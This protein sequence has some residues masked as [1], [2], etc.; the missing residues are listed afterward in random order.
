ML[1]FDTV[2]VSAALITLVFCAQF[3]SARNKFDL[4]ITLPFPEIF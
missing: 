3:H 2:I 1:S 4:S